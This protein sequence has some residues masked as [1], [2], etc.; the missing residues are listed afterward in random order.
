[1]FICPYTGQKILIKT[2]ILKGDPFFLILFQG[3]NNIHGKLKISFFLDVFSTEDTKIN[4]ME[5][6]HSQMGGIA[7]N[8]F[9]VVPCNKCCNAGIHRSTGRKLLQSMPLDFRRSSETL[10][11]DKEIR[12]PGRGIWKLWIVQ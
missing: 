9:S 8:Q 2:N 3:L 6:I 4:K 7:C 12:A 5:R 1:M 10:Q 11:A